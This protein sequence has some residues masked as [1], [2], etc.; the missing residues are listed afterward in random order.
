[1]K[2]HGATRAV[3]PQ[4]DGGSLHGPEAPPAPVR[5]RGSCLCGGVRVTV[6]SAPGAMVF[7]H[8]RQ[9][10]KGAGAPFQA[11]VPVSRAACT[12]DDPEGLLRA[13]SASADKLRCFCGR[14]G[15]PIYSVRHGAAMLRLRAGIF[16]DFVP[17]AY[18]GHI[19]AADAA[20]WWTIDDDLPRYAATE[21]GREPGAG[22]AGE[23]LRD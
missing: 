10:R 18:G 21:P 12:V 8:C 16:D 20:P 17:D 15:A 3:A 23:V 19:H 11:V 2:K 13:Y 22:A 7:C 14:C 4:Q 5:L 6:E 9:C 1:M